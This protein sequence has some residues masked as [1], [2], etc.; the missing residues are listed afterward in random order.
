MQ[1]GKS[2]LENERVF[3]SNDYSNRLVHKWRSE[4]AGILVGKNTA[5]K[6]DPAL[7]NRLWKGKNPVR[8]VIDPKLE[9][10]TSLKVFNDEAKTIIYNLSKNASEGNIEYIELGKNDFLKKMLASLYENNIQ[11]VLVEGGAKTLQS[12]I[13]EDLWDEA[14]VITNRE[15]IIEEGINAPEMKNFN[16]VRQESYYSDM[17]DYFTRK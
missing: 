7:T 6:D 11:S 1:T 17:I 13:D 9:L 15:M 4:E 12:F 2:D 16:M 8:I 14:R 5:L 10:A 3:I